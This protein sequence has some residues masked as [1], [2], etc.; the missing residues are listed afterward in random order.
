MVHLCI[1]CWSGPPL[2]FHV[3]LSLRHLR[4]F[5]HWQTTVQ[6]PILHSPYLLYETIIA[7][8]APV[9]DRIYMDTTILICDLRP[10]ALV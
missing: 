6:W 8:L 9:V 4:S 7:V 5:T 1:Q 2:S 3:D 10:W